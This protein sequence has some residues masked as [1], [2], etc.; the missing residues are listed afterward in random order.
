[1]HSLLDMSVHLGYGCFE[2]DFRLLLRVTQNLSER[3]IDKEC[4]CKI[5]RHVALLVT[6]I[7]CKDQNF[8]I[9]PRMLSNI[10]YFYFSKSTF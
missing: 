5:F 3:C 8:R 1:M 9:I 6:E 4:I 10:L 2:I 7:S